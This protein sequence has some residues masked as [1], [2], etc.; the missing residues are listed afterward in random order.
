MSEITI[1]H[2][3]D[4]HFKK[5]KDEKNKTFR[6][7]VQTGLIDAIGAH[8]KKHG[9]PDF[10]AVT[11]DIA[12]SGQKHEYDEAWE[13]FEELKKI[14]APG[15]VFLAVP[16]NHDVD[17]E[18]VSE[19]FSMYPI[20]KAGQTDRFLEDKSQIKNFINIK[21]SAFRDFC[22]R[23]QPGLYDDYFW[24]KNF[25][26]KQVSVVGLNSAWASEGDRDRFQIALGYPQVYA[27]LVKAS[28]PHRVILMHHP[29]FNWLE[30]RDTQ[31]WS[32]EVFNKCGLILHGH[33][34]MDSALSFSTPSDSCLSIGANA[35]YTHDG[36]IGFQFIEVKFME[37]RV[38]VRVCPY[39]LEELDRIVFLPNTSRWVGQEGKPCFE[40]ETR[41]PCK[42]D[43]ED[44][45]PLQIPI[46][47]REWLV[48]F[49]SKMDIEQLDPNA[50]AY[51]V[52][53]PEVYIPIETANPFYRPKDEKSMKERGKKELL[54][55]LEKDKESKESKEPQYIDIEGL[56]GRE[57][58]ILL[59]G[60]A[61]T[62]KTTL[63][64][65]LAYTITHGQG[66]VSLC[67]YLPIV[68]F[69]KDLWS[70]YK[71]QLPA[72]RTG[73]VITFLS[74]L[75]TYLEN[76]V[77]GLNYEVVERFI[78]RDRALFLL[79]GLD[80]VPEQVR[81]GLVEVIAG[82]RLENKN[83]RFLL[84]GRPHGIDTA[85]IQY[86]GE[87]LRDIEPLD[88]EK[89]MVFVSNWFRVVSGQAVGLADMTAAEMIGDIRG[90]PHVSVFTQNPLLLTAVCILYQDKKRLPDQRAELYCRIV[91]NLISRRFH[92]IMDTEKASRVDDFLKLLAFHM[93]ENNIKSID[94]GEAKQLLKTI[95]PL[96]EETT[97]QYNRRIDNL[98]QEIEPR[99]GLLK[100]PGEGEVEFLHLTFQEFLAARHMLYMDLDYQ[101]FLEKQWWKE[102]L[103]L[104]FGLVSRERKGKANQ[105]VKEILS[106]THQDAQ[107]R[108]RLWML[109]G[110]ALRDIQAYKRDKEVANLSGEKLIHII[111]SNASLGERFEAGEILGVL[112]DP[113]IKEYPM[114]KVE[115]GEFAMGSDKG[116]YDDEE[117][118]HRVYLYEFMMGKYPV[119][120]EEFKVFVDDG[121]YNNE[122]YWTKEGRKWKEKEKISLPGY[123]YDGKW[124]RPNF[125]VMGVSWYEAS[126][127]AS[128]LS[129]NTGKEYRLPTEAQWEKA[130]RGTDGREYPWGKQFNKNLCNS[131]ECGLKR[132]SPVGIFPNGKSPY[133]CLDMSGNVYEWCS[134]WFEEDYYKKSPKK[135]PRGPKNGSH[136]VLRG[137]FWG[138]VAPN[139]RAAYRNYDLP[140]L[141]AVGVGFRLLRSF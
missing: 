133:G 111:E 51:H 34:H 103:L 16:G 83:N 25:Q 53:L 97:V 110:K 57:V 120:N 94:V 26:D 85:V 28:M 86:F 62:G 69:L 95:F 10:V 52:P 96:G 45:R 79:D 74:L 100:R 38:N 116:Y 33:M 135:N 124:N 137:G 140:A 122:E 6:Q 49:H 15:T 2:L 93:Q 50:R 104:Y 80:E 12:F 41:R 22:R 128:W 76:K 134:D 32:G 73:A 30:E 37:E 20:V 47:Y 114:V 65:H 101:Q 115:A 42:G 9:S 117:P 29:L 88:N 40:L 48:Q 11:G 102:T 39:K 4:I 8:V 106:G 130:A 90:N 7:N 3:S 58:C 43:E 24:V 138:G 23:L 91:D 71:N 75:K 132:T 89:V 105:M 81:R 14:L 131:R 125:P 139:C 56:L 87:Y 31:K 119:T 46:E 99:C 98:F 61:G 68:V 5:K 13:F 17:R 107:V 67:E 118:I 129:K 84:T 126:A 70:I 123:W 64:K 112:G 136:R 19:F 78:S 121:G 113:R 21:F 63:V 18:Q 108:Y 35:T 55:G 66:T 36:Y 44:L 82:F 109:G 59:R 60:A 127:Y 72:K 27:A 141:R 1:L 77:P 54:E 92:Q